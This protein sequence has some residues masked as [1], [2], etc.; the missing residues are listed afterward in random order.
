MAA[1]V[2][3]DGKMVACRRFDEDCIIIDTDTREVVRCA[4]RRRSARD[5]SARCMML[6]CLV[7]GL[8]GKV[9]IQ[10]AVLAC[11]GIDSPDISSRVR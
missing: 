4:S 9:R 8:C 3:P 1:A 7:S 10:R 2:W 6:W 11:R 5:E